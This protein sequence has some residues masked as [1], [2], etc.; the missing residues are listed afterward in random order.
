MADIDIDIDIDSDS[1]PVVD[2]DD[3]QSNIP[4]KEATVKDL[5]TGF[6]QNKLTSKELVQYYLQQ[7]QELNPL[8]RAAEEA[9]KRRAKAQ[10][11]NTV[12]AGGLDGIPILLQKISLKQQQDHMHCWG[13]SYAAPSGW[14][15]RSG[16]GINPYN[17]SATPGGSSSGSA[18]AVASNL[19]A[20]AL[21]TETDGSILN[22]CSANS[23]V[24]IKPT[25]GLTS[26][27]GLYQ[28]PLHKTLLG[29]YKTRINLLELNYYI[30][31]RPICRSWTVADAAYVLDSI[32]GDDP[33]DADATLKL[34]HT[35]L[36]P[37]GLKGK[38]L[39]I[40]R[41][42]FFRY[43]KEFHEKNTALKQHILTLT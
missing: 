37:D 24:G 3:L 40:V 39:G 29:I 6:I 18:I 19:V 21:G 25:L 36:K 34:K 12:E 23:V 13:Q 42:P 41:N 11:E 27:G 4:I 28:S 1:N 9:D 38:T 15:A 43:I 14:C 7:I 2:N 22:P 30:I 31:N 26:R 8:L 35:Y 20:V 16:Q 5:Q 33:Y 17:A 10:E 32:V